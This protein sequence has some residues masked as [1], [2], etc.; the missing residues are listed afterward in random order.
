MSSTSVTAGLANALAITISA[1]CIAVSRAQGASRRLRSIRHTRMNGGADDAPA[2]HDAPALWGAMENLDTRAYFQGVVDLL[3][4][5]D[6]GL[7]VHEIFT[8]Y[9]N[10]N[11]PRR[12]QAYPASKQQI[13]RLAAINTYIEIDHAR[14]EPGL[15]SV[16]RIDLGVYAR[17][18]APVLEEP[19][20]VAGECSSDEERQIFEDKLLADDEPYA[21]RYGDAVGEVKDENPVVLFVRAAKAV[22]GPERVPVKFTV[23]GTHPGRNVILFGRVLQMQDD[24]AVADEITRTLNL[25]WD[26]IMA[27]G[28]GF[29]GVRWIMERV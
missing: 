25:S 18:M 7:T 13:G 8:H 22:A 10:V 29:W 27:T 14:N 19:L 28:A 4:E 15:H 23:V 26:A 12:L 3:D 17:H 16:R 2:P 11:N 21:R 1:V 9:V 20:P 24:D 5:S 6:N